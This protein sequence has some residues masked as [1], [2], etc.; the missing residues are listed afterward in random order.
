MTVSNVTGAGQGQH[1]RGSPCNL[2]QGLPRAGRL[3]ICPGG[4]VLLLGSWR[5]GRLVA[6]ALGV[7]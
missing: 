2:L 3:T 6:L 5:F 4:L 1:K 7:R